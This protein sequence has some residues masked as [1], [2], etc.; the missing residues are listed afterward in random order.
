MFD[1]HSLFFFFLFCFSSFILWASLSPF[2]L[3]FV[4]PPLFFYHHSLK[5]FFFVFLSLFFDQ[6]SKHSFC[7]PYFIL[8]PSFRTSFF[9]INHSLCFFLFYFPSFIFWPSF[10][11]FFLFSFSL[12][13]SLTIIPYHI[14]HFLFLRWFFDNQLLTLSFLFCL[15]YSLTIIPYHFFFLFWFPCFNLWPSC[16]IYLSF[17][18]PPLFFDHHS[19]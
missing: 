10:P 18:F 11:K 1:H 4:F 16:P 9:F 13:Y 2:S 14:F 15:L 8:W 19:L 5:F 7:L 12:L 3:F 17:S 6:H